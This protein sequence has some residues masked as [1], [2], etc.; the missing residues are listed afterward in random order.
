MSSNELSQVRENNQNLHEHYGMVQLLF[1]ILI[2]YISNPININHFDF[3]FL[4]NLL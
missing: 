3:F 1:F 2:I 4:T